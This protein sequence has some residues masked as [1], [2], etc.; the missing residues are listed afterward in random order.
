MT[1]NLH[2]LDNGCANPR[3]PLLAISKSAVAFDA[4]ARGRLEVSLQLEGY[5]AA[6][7]LDC[8]CCYELAGLEGVSWPVELVPPPYSSPLLARLWSWH[9]LIKNR[10]YR[11][12]K[13]AF[14]K[15]NGG[16]S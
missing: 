7:L 14:Q 13:S 15:A 8:G 16:Q 5:Q 4:A 2:T 12:I 11:M 1:V 10:L 9:F 6:R 3:Y